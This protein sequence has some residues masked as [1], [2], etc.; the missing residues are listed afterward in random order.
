MFLFLKKPYPYNAFS[1]KEVY[2]N[3]I[4]A[5]FVSLFLIVFEPFGISIWETNHKLLKLIGFGCVSF[6]SILLFRLISHFLIKKNKPE[7]TWTVW[8]EIVALTLVVVVIAFGNLCY[9]NFIRISHF[10]FKELSF[11]LIA[12]S[13]LAFFPITANITLKYNRFVILNQKDAALMETEVMEFQQRQV[14]DILAKELP[15]TELKMLSLL[16]ENEKEKIELEPDRLF[17]IESADNYSNIV[18]FK[19]QKVVKHLIRGS[20]K[21]IEAQIDIPHI[22]RCHRSYIVNLKQ[23]EHIKG[24]AQGYK[25]EFKKELSDTV[26]VSRNYSKTLFERL[27]SLK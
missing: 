24:N 27:E 14:V 13:L 2:S 6:I 12:T 8:K 10:G 23:I 5:C 11:A 16:S 26:S 25:I 15:R 9:S 22:I 19:D 7:E 4:I 18:Y 20:L 3:F 21:R 17:Y 1:F